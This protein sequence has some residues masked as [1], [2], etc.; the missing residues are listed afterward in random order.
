MQA[1]QQQIFL[2]LRDK[3][4]LHIIGGNSKAFYGSAQTGTPLYVGDYAGVIDYQPTELVLTARCGTPLSDIESLLAAHGQML[5]F[6][7]PHFAD[8]ATLGGT[9]A[10]GLS[11]SR[12]AYAGAVRDMVLG[13]RMINGRGELLK[14]GGQ[15]MKNVAGFDISRLQVGAL[16]TLGVLLDISLK[17]LPRPE[18]ELTLVFEMPEQQ[19]LT[20]MI[21]WG[22][23]NLPISAL[24]FVDN[25]L[26]LRLS[27]AET[28]IKRV[29]L[30][31]GGTILPQADDFWLSIREQ[32][33][34]FFNT[35]LPLW[36]LSLA[37]AT[38][39]LPLSGDCLMDWG[40]AL[41][42]LKTDEPSDKLFAVM[43]NTSGHACRF[44]STQGFISQA[45]TPN[46]SHLQQRIKLAFDPD[47]IFNLNGR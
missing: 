5:G 46:L 17:V 38:N 11:G 34:A 35:E 27:G 15:V 6:E 3:T 19:A 12:R 31:L 2:A 1:I 4:P 14:F 24:C 45:L 37:P 16:G 36:R 20:Q 47:G 21:D 10:T 41:R 18:S 44:R 40:G 23:K 22:R 7:P 39:P 32:Q 30:T 25:G 33:H 42:W 13:V 9:I 29:H 43:Q 28:A 26:Y 8:T